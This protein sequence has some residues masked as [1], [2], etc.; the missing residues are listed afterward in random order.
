MILL[1]PGPVTLSPGVRRA[2]QRED[3]CHRE[4]EFAD[5]TLDLR[6]RLEGIYPGAEDYAAVLLTGSGTA[7]VEAMLA[8]L[9]SPA[10]RT[11]VVTNGVY[12]ERMADMLA[13]QGKPYITVTAPWHEG[14]PLDKIAGALDGDPAI[15]F[16]AAVHHE[17]T[18]GRLNAVGELG[19]LCKARN[20]GLLLDTVS[21]F[22]AEEICFDEWNLT[23]AAATA[24]K[25]LH[26]IPGT[27]FVLARK[28]ALEKAAG[29]A[30]VLYLDLAAYYREQKDGWSPFT[31]SVQAFF[32]LQAALEEFEGEGGWQ[33]RQARYRALSSRIRQELSAHGISC[34]LP[35]TAHASMLTAYL[36][37][38]GLTYGDLHD[39]LKAAGFIVYAGQG[40]LSGSI[41]RIAT[42]GAIADADVERLLTTF[43][44][45][46]Q[47]RAHEC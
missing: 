13:R 41:F 38:D 8:S 37:P 12:G 5:L 27:A 25:C 23:A 39:A 4:R 43:R 45:L 14:L 9:V 42:M 47:G 35:E 34:L 21:S 3:W 20:V 44:A 17:T 6:R 19:A 26:G 29:N 2:L 28:A 30:P 11:L 31:Q 33:A 7:A 10:D 36:L 46:L 32:A 40:R 22:G 1:N 15:R 24:N 18:T 16:V